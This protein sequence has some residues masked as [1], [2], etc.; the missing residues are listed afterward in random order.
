ML[1]AVPGQLR[2]EPRSIAAATGPT[3]WPWS[4][5]IAGAASFW[6]AVELYESGSLIDVVNSARLTAQVLRGARKA[7]TSDGVRVLA[8]GR[9]PLAG[10][11][12][13]VDFS[14]GRLRKFRV[15]VPVIEISSWCWLAI[16]DGPFHAVTVQ[17]RQAGVRWQLRVRRS[18]R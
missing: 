11:L 14:L 5:R 2:A 18:W 7:E 12:P 17:C 3:L 15:E 8:W 4:Y 9:V 1:T 6:P 13:L 16:A 10:G